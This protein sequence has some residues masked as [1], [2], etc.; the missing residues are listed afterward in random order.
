MEFQR[1]SKKS[2]VLFR[3]K[4]YVKKF[5]L[6]RDFGIVFRWIPWAE[7]ALRFSVVIAKCA[8]CSSVMRNA[9][10]RRIRHCF[11][12]IFP[13]VTVPVGVVCVVKNRFIM[14]LSFSDL[15]SLF[16]DFVRNLKITYLQRQCDN[17]KVGK[18]NG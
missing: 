5:D 11:F 14:D 9:I 16:E 18:E 7:E 1:L 2:S 6:E 8:K 10:K 4:A 13:Y 3:N 17:N 12:L 15:L